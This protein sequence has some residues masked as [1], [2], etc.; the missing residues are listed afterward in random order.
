MCIA[1]VM[2]EYEQRSRTVQPGIAWELRN[3]FGYRALLS[4]RDGRGMTVFE[5]RIEPL[6]LEGVGQPLRFLTRGQHGDL[7]R[8]SR[9]YPGLLAHSSRSKT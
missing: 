3:R 6:D 5:E 8:N 4:A 9:R 7:C 1:F 2:K